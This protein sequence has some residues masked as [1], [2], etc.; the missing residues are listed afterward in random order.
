M[1]DQGQSLEKLLQKLKSQHNMDE[2]ASEHPAASPASVPSSRT[3]DWH[4]LLRQEAQHSAEDQSSRSAWP[5]ETTTP[6]CERSSAV[7]MDASHQMLPSAI[8]SIVSAHVSLKNRRALE[9]MRDHRDQLLRQLRAVTG[10]DPT[11]AIERVEEDIRAIEQGLEQLK[12]PPGALPENEW[13]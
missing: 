13:H 3:D 5:G 9:E 7:A 8:G 6:A 10:L 1:E 4:D 2:P 11:T 12:P